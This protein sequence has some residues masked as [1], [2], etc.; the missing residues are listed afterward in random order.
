MKITENQ[1]LHFWQ[2]STKFSL[3]KN[4]IF[5]FLIRENNSIKIKLKIK[6]KLLKNV[7]K[8]NSI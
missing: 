4:L 3:T 8:F 6:L 7:K 5:Y 2:N 1:Y